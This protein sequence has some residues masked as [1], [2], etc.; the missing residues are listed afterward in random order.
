[1]KNGHGIDSKS[2]AGETPALPGNN[3]LASILKKAFPASG[4]FLILSPNIANEGFI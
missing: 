4:R 3:G 1:M 2:I